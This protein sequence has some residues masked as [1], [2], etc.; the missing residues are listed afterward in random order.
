MVIWFG[1]N[2]VWN[3]RKSTSLVYLLHRTLIQKGW[4]SVQKKGERKSLSS[5]GGYDLPCCYFANTYHL[6]E[7]GIAIILASASP[8]TLWPCALILMPWFWSVYL[9]ER[10]DHSIGRQRPYEGRVHGWACSAVSFAEPSMS[11]PIFTGGVVAFRI[12]AQF[13]RHNFMRLS[14]NR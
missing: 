11:S 2:A 8:S 10:R 12:C 4:L 14:R 6:A 7:G 9:R 13:D 3:R 5:K 1:I